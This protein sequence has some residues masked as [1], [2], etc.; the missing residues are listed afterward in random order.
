MCCT[1]ASK[2]HDQQQCCPSCC[3]MSHNPA[4]AAGSLC[5]R[6]VAQQLLTGHRRLRGRRRTVGRSQGAQSTQRRRQWSSRS[7]QHNEQQCNTSALHN[8]SFAQLGCQWLCCHLLCLWLLHPAVDKL[9]SWHTKHC[10]AT[11]FLYITKSG[12]QGS[13]RHHQ[14]HSC[15][16][17]L[18]GCWEWGGYGPGCGSGLHDQPAQSHTCGPRSLN[19][20]TDPLE[21]P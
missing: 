2:L 13:I 17:A 10:C 14:L 19:C 11:S 16:Q 5:C 7:A 6:S 20:S 21:R 8:A 18:R 9:Q 12:S 3:C 1:Q 15:R 4:H